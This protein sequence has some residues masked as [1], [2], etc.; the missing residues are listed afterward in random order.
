VLSENTST[1]INNIIHHNQCFTTPHEILPFYCF[2]H[3]VHQIVNMVLTIID[4]Q[5][6]EVCSYVKLLRVSVIESETLQ[7]NITLA[8]LKI[9]TIDK[10][11]IRSIPLFVCKRW[12]SLHAMIEVSIKIYNLIGPEQMWQISKKDIQS[13]KNSF[14][15]SN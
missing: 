13:F 10:V 9:P 6:K 3:S 11:T 15:R 12:N 1:I 7:T 8:N 5:I 2:A 14:T 4:L